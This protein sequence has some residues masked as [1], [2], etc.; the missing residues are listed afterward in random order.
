MFVP[1]NDR[2]VTQLRDRSSFEDGDE[3]ALVNGGRVGRRPAGARRHDLPVERAGDIEVAAT[4]T[5]RSRPRS[6]T[7][8]PDAT[9]AVFTPKAAIEAEAADLRRRMLLVADRGALSSRRPLPT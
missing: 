7:G 9:L 4:A 1:L 8:S 5:A 3:I 2:L 6:P